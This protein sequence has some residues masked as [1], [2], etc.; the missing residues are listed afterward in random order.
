MPSF[1]PW[2]RREEYALMREIIDDH[3][4]LPLTFDQWEKE[5]ESQRAAKKRDGVNVVPVFISPDEFLTFCKEKHIS[6][7]S[8]N[9]AQF[10]NSRGAAS[11]SLG[12]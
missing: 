5:A 10:A 2:Y 6:C 4:K 3:D 8:E 11:Y 9:C 1:A 7:N 12:L